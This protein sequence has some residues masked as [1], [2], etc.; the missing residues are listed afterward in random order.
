MKEIQNRSTNIYCFIA[1]YIV[2]FEQ[3][4]VRREK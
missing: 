3:V 2:N 4:Y 1:L